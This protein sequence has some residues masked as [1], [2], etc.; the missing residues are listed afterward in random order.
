MNTE[1]RTNQL[2]SYASNSA[3]LVLVLL[4]M[5][6]YNYIGAK[7]LAVYSIFVTAV[8][9]LNYLFIYKTK[10]RL[11]IWS[12]YTML[13]IYMAVCTIMLGYNYGFNLYSMSTIPLIYYVKYIGTKLGGKD[14]KPVFWTIA[15]ML[16]CTTSSLY[17]VYNGPYYNIQGIPQILFLGINIV[18][19]CSF[20][21]YFS[22][23]MVI[24]V[25]DSE[26][27]LALQANYDALTKLS[28]RY[29]MRNILLNAVQQND[30]KS[31]I[32][33]IDIDKFKGI[34]DTYGHNIGDEVLKNLA[35]LMNQVCKNC[36]VSRWGGEEFLIYGEEESVSPAI[37][38]ELRKTVEDFSLLLNDQQIKF[39]ITAGVSSHKKDQSMDKWIISA[40]N[41][42]YSGKAEG[43]NVVVY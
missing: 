13:T 18:T 36:S 21:F 26:E 15:I 38:E 2:V 39:T 3:I 43:R 7:I 23:R 19:V 9:L 33:M 30:T 17:T 1:M 41:K 22:R 28:N 32:A 4:M 31:W 40:D 42:L 11:Y 25:T 27:K 5:A 20:L 12:T 35:D 6:I 8:Y 14:P 16:S 34:N 37:I 24:L 29:F 10:L